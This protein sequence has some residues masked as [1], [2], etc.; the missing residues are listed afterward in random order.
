MPASRAGDAALEEQAHKAFIAALQSDPA[1]RRGAELLTAPLQGLIERI[2]DTLHKQQQR[3]AAPVVATHGEKQPP[4]VYLIWHP[5]DEALAEPLREGLFEAGFDVLEP[6]SDPSANETQ[7]FDDHRT[8]LV[9]CTAALV[10]VG[11]AGEFWLGPQLSDMQKAVGW[12]QGRPLQARG[13]YC[14]PPTDGYK[15]RLRAHGLIAMQAFDGHTPVVL[16][17]FIDRVRA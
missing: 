2:H 7:I 4:S 3:Q 10:C 12:R 5:L 14:G 9:E 8:K 6:L 16:Q 15:K 11:H 1:A 17:S 13:V